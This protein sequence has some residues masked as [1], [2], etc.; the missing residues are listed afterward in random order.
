[1]SLS[2]IGL[3]LLSA[4]PP[5][6]CE[7]APGEIMER[8]EA[9]MGTYATLRVRIPERGPACDVVDKTMSE[10]FAEVARLEQLLSEWRQG[11]ELTAVNNAA[12]GTPVAV[13]D[14]VF[15]L[16]ERAFDYAARSDGA[17]DP[18][19]ASLWGL[20]TFGEDGVHTLP[21][22]AEVERR[23]AL[24][25]WRAVK[26]D[27]Q[28]KTVHLPTTGMKLGLGGIAKGWAVDKVVARLRAAGA[29]DFVVQLGGET[30]VEGELRP[31]ASK[32]ALRDP[33]G[34]GPFATLTWQGAVNTSGDYER[35]FMQDG[36]RYH[37]II[38]PAT[39]RPAVRTRS[40]TVLAR[41][42]TSADALATAVFVLGPEQGIA[43]VESLPGVEAIVV[44]A[45][46]RVWLSSG[47]PDDLELVPPS[48]GV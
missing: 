27:P 18:T 10:S 16:V 8:T 37:H 39:A 36:V 30:F 5:P 2:L 43:L 38:D 23:R 40:A 19:F 20:W 6:D 26:L 44:A 12:G 25:G 45:D 11:T 1:V 28:R 32:V 47:V 35:F 22:P 9:H 41:D 31:G 48:D 13:S 14:E 4:A 24:V 3:L 42:A 15:A 34:A 33:R 21:D 29:H 7:V 46:N 17:F